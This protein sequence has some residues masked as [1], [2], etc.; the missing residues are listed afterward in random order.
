[1]DQDSYQSE[2]NRENNRENMRNI[3]SYMINNKSVDHDNGW[4]DQIEIDARQIGE[5]SG[6]LRW[7]HNIASS[8]FLKKYWIVTGIN[9]GLAALIVTFNS[10]TGAT[11]IQDALDPYKIASLILSALVG[12][13]VTYGSVKNYGARV[14]AHQVS[15]GNFLALFYTIKNQLHLNRRDRQFGK[16]FIEW[17]Q[18]EYTDLSSNPDAPNIPE[19][20]QKTYIVKIQGT[21]MAKY[22]DIESI[23][24]KKDSPPREESPIPITIIQDSSFRK[25]SRAYTD[26]RR[27]GNR[28]QGITT[29]ARNID[30][31]NENDNYT[32]TIPSPRIDNQLLTPKDKWQLSRFYD[33]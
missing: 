22:N 20:V 33:K 17:I 32:V 30:S 2:N 18:K 13:V 6:G 12:I 11:C 9:I 16:D 29:S 8:V 23:D 1:M 28:R 27:R 4:N 5:K 3:S 14:T 19:F 31:E 25:Q 26:V 24:I 15:E 10:I 7:M 21:N